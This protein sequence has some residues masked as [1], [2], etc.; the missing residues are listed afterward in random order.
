VYAHRYC[1]ATDKTIGAH[2]SVCEVLRS[3]ISIQSY[4]VYRKSLIRPT[5]N[6]CHTMPYPAIFTIKTPKLHR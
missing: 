6:P 2:S 1:T 4:H 5:A 3:V